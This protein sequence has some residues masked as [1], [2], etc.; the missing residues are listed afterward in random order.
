MSIAKQARVLDQG[1]AATSK[2]ILRD[3]R[4]GIEPREETLTQN[5]VSE[6]VA[7]TRRT[8]LNAGASE[9]ARR[10]EARLYG[11]DIALWFTNA[12]GQ[13]AGVYL[14]AKVL[15][16]DNTYRRLDHRNQ[17]GR[18]FD[19]LIGAA[20][21]DGVL[22]GYAFHNGLR[23]PDPSKSACEHGIGSPEINGISVASAS[24]MRSHLQRR[25]MR[26]SIE[27][28]CSPLSC[29]VRHATGPGGAGPAGGD[30]SGSGGGGGGGGGRGPADGTDPDLPSALIA[31]SQS[32]QG[33]EAR[34][35]TSESLPAY[36]RALAERMDQAAVGDIASPDD[37]Y[38]DDLDW[39]RYYGPG[40]YPGPTEWGDLY[41]FFTAVLIGPER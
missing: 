28:F 3:H 26:S 8:K 25:V 17:H 30:G 10:D 14:Q 12:A 18:Q 37:A 11:A 13:F 34:L 29:L 31:L 33:S 36:V 16:S 39:W 27:E 19:T 21:R 41:P 23:A 1:A 35:H 4:N 20:R 6:Y 7:R 9:F 40:P 2:R 22:A 38:I 5:F 24:S 32:W 15:R